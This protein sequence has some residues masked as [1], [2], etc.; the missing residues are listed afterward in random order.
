ME[1]REAGAVRILSF[2]VKTTESHWCILSNGKLYMGRWKK[3]GKHNQI[4]ILK[5][6]ECWKEPRA[7]AILVMCFIFRTWDPP[8]QIFVCIWKILGHLLKGAHEY[9]SLTSQRWKKHFSPPKN[10]QI[11]LLAYAPHQC[12]CL[13]D[14]SSFGWGMRNCGCLLLLADSSAEL[15][16]S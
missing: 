3:G 6:L 5:S 16:T 1:Q 8:G 11:V 15:L 14:V 10:F 13:S 12:P 2:R 4:F 7:D 9:M